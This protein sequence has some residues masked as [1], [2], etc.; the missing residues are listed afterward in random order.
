MKIYQGVDIVQIKKLKEI[1]ERNRSF[2]TDIFT[3]QERDYCM[4]KK[5]PSIHFA[6]RFAAKEAGLKA[7]GTGISGIDN[8]FQDIETLPGGS[9]KPELSLTGW[10]KKISLKKRID[11]MTVSIS[12]TA[13]YAVATVIL[14]GNEE[15]G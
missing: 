7:L 15:R 3:E 10:I 12:H 9:G 2:V 1:M 5:D 13:D 4:S 14:T 11:Q 8:S 6:G